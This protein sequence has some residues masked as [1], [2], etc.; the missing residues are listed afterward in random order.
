MSSATWRAGGIVLKSS[1]RG[2]VLSAGI[3]CQSWSAGYRRCAA[4]GCALRLCCGIENCLA[5]P[6]AG[7]VHVVRASWIS[8]TVGFLAAARLRQLLTMARF[9]R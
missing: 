1:P 7:M 5:W 2:G 6:L 4:S 8:A 9:S 3:G